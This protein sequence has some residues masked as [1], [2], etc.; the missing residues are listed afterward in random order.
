M[1]KEKLRV[2]NDSGRK[3]SAAQGLEL[4]QAMESGEQ[5]KPPAIPTGYFA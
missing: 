1:G 5:E 4:L 3:S 2:W